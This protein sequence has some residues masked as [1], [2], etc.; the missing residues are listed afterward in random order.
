MKQAI[1]L[2]ELDQPAVAELVEERV[3]VEFFCLPHAAARRPASAGLHR[4]LESSSLT[5]K[6]VPAL[7]ARLI[8]L[9]EPGHVAQ[10]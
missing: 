1:D 7:G 10:R 2:D 6:G 8:H 4:R 5:L 3:K 9:E